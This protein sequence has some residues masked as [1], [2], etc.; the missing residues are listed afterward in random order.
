MPIDFSLVGQ[1]LPVLLKGL[2]ITALVSLIGIPLGIL[3]GTIAAYAAQSRTLLRPVALAYVELVRNIPYLILVYLSFF[4]LPKLGVPA[5]AMSVAIGCTA[6]YTGGYFCEVLR[7]ALKSV[8]RGQSS[9]ALSLGM[10]YWQTQRHIVVPQLFGFLIPP[11]T[12]LVIMMFKDSAIFSVMSL[13]EMTYQS[14]LLTANT[15]AYLEVLGTT[16][17]LYWVCSVLMA[18]AGRRLETLVRRKARQA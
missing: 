13:P 3:I 4:G 2:R 18:G 6:F 14:N 10:T 11:T 8:P 15:F 17:L 1:S 7:A 9:A 5:T 16:A 12:S